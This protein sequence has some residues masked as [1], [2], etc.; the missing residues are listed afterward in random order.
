MVVM[1]RPAARFPLVAAKVKAKA[2]KPPPP[3]WLH[4]LLIGGAPQSG[5]YNRS[6]STMLAEVGE[7]LLKLRK[8][9]KVLLVAKYTVTDHGSSEEFY[10]KAEVRIVDPYWASLLHEDWCHCSLKKFVAPRGT[11]LDLDDRA[12]ETGLVA[13]L[14]GAV[15][16]VVDEGPE[17]RLSFAGWQVRKDF[18]VVM[19][20]YGRC[21]TTSACLRAREAL[22]K[23]FR[24]EKLTWPLVEKQ[25]CALHMQLHPCKSICPHSHPNSGK[26]EMVLRRRNEIFADFK[27]HRGILLGPQIEV[28]T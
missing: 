2:K 9:L 21:S 24:K 11:F 26:E 13:R 8:G 25:E 22:R 19:F 15:Q 23:E 16:R 6:T 5:G 10:T 28:S 1:R 17:R 27:K 7:A 3:A 20:P 12:S 18:T 4:K 14:F